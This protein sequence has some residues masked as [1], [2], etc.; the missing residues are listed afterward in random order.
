VRLCLDTSAYSAFKRGHDGTLD[1]LQRADTIVLPAVVLGELHAGFRI[2]SRERENHRDLED[3]LGSPRV[4]IASVDDETA[5]RYADI[6]AY[7]R[8]QGTPIPTNDIWIAS[9]AMQWGLRVLTFDEHFG[10]VPQ[11]SV[12]SLE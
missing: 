1:A 9:V 11:V 6:V 4:R 8:E 7:L 3:F 2:G 5:H 10:R 12:L